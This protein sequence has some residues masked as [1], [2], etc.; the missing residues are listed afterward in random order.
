MTQSAN[1]MILNH[2]F[3]T[4]L[5]RG[6]RVIKQIILERLRAILIAWNLFHYVEEKTYSFPGIQQNTHTTKPRV[7][8]I[9]H[10]PMSFQEPLSSI[11][12]SI[13]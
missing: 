8:E 13:R 2:L 4:G 3:I 7:S 1:S 11:K 5:L 12:E 6:K 10:D 9:I